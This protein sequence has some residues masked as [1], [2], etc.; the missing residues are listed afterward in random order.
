MDHAESDS[1][2]SS[3]TLPSDTSTQHTR[4]KK[5]QRKWKR[6]KKRTPCSNKENEPINM[7]KSVLGTRNPKVTGN[8]ETR[9]I[10]PAQQIASTSYLRKAL[11]HVRGMGQFEFHAWASKP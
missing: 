2:K 9:V 11:G 1:S 8:S 7:I 4:H 10:E 6:S 3:E 5:K